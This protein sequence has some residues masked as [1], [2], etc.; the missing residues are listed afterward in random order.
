M[1]AARAGTR[2]AAGRA[3][4]AA[5]GG[6][7]HLRITTFGLPLAVAKIDAARFAPPPATS[8]FLQRLGLA[9]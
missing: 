2:G 4:D 9:P 8:P 1:E 6:T 3:G 5:P 7:A